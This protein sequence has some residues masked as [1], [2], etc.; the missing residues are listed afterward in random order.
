MRLSLGAALLP[1]LLL[2]LFTGCSEDPGAKGG[3]KGGDKKSA[4]RGEAPEEE[5]IAVRVTPL[6]VGP[7]SETYTTST[8]LRAEQRATITAR[9]SGIIDTIYMEEGDTVGAGDTLARLERGAQLIAVERAKVTLAARDSEFRRQSDLHKKG[10][11]SDVEYEAS[12]ASF[13]DAKQALELSQLELAYTTIRAPF[14][15]VVLQR[16]FDKGASVGGGE[17]LFE[18]ADTSPL[19]ADV[20]VPERHV[21]SL[22]QGQRVRL[23]VDAS[24]EILEGKI[25]RLSPFV[26]PATGTVK[27]TI[28]ADPQG[29][30]LRPGAFVRVTI[31]T[32]TRA[33]ATSVPR[34][35][36][37]SEGR[38]WS[39]FEQVEEGDRVKKHEVIL[40]YEEGDRVEVRPA[41]PD[42][43]PFKAGMAIVSSGAPALS[44]GAKIQ[45]IQPKV[46]ES[47]ESKDPKDAQDPKETDPKAE[48]NQ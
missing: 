41:A 37:V 28:E 32:S 25:A 44:D 22:K 40:G 23:V 20:K 39:I 47:K 48:G 8:T 1:I 45:V 42:A 43:P 29:I 21:K 35:A 24:G 16:M 46:P 10:L 7:I 33:T 26:D 19:F 18:V 31:V 30:T 9:T 36:L 13:K 2:I 38:R 15:G 27:V 12:E 5:A 3:G 14:G 17:A 11:A 4:Q 6:E 34:L